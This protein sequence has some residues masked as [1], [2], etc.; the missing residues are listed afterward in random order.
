VKW[1]G[2][3]FG[4]VGRAGVGCS[5]GGEP[6]RRTSPWEGGGKERN[7][8]KKSAKT[9]DGPYFKSMG[10]ERKFWFNR[11]NG[12]GS[13]VC[14]EALGGGGGPGLFPALDQTSAL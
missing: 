4:W 5:L 11:L 6:E 7:G 3:P 9:F 8:V 13:S 1:R 14:L 2:G 12:I 10:E